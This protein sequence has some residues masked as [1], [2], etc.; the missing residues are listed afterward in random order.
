MIVGCLQMNTTIGEFTQ[1]AELLLSGYQDAVE[2]GA[3]IVVGS[4]LSLSGYPPRDLLHYQSF[5]DKQ[6]ATLEVMTGQIG[7]VPLITGVFL[8]NPEPKG[9]ALFNAAVWLESGKQQQTFYKCLL[10]NYDVFDENRY[11]EPSGHPAYR[12]WRGKRI[13]VTI[14]ED[15]WNDAEK[16]PRPAYHRDPVRELTGQNIDLL[17]NVSASPWFLGKGRSRLELI[18]NIA[19]ENSIPVVQANLIGGNDELIFDGQ[20]AV[21]GSEGQLLAK[22]SGFQEEQ[23]IVDL[24]QP[25]REVRHEG[26]EEQLFQALTLGVRDYVKKCGF[27]Q[28]AIGLSGGIDSAITAV[29][30]CEALG[31]EAVL[32]V[33]MPSQYSSQGSVDDAVALAK[34][35]GLDYQK[36]PIEPICQEVR[37]S[38]SSLFEGL[39]EDVTEENIQSRA[40]GL[41]MMAISNKLNRLVL[42]TGNK[43]EL[44]VGYCT[45]YGDMCGGLSVINDVPKTWVYRLS[46][47]MNREKEVIPHETIEKPPSAELRPDQK[48]EDSLPPYD[49][50]D[51]ILHRY[52][53]EFQSSGEISTQGKHDPDLVQRWLRQVDLNEYKR[54]QA[55]PGLKVTS[56]AFGIGRRMPVAQRYRHEEE[57]N[58]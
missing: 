44:A 31:P 46:K 55:A 40:R 47:W 23:L 56:K 20:S 10:P 24:D 32:G 25:A 26:E 14:C 16:L 9:H 41:I 13:G 58:K 50:L 21:V 22:A 37:K 51:D 1:N 30:A 19:R 54:R 27:S 11:F 34:N 8:P 4:E 39:A 2:Q 33:L 7:A 3:E 36:I 52:I 5:I 42:T 17:I 35:L 57:L 53:E 43:S 49:Q 45:L 12:E 18:Q 28:V 6:M 15:I 48:D 38:L 29:I